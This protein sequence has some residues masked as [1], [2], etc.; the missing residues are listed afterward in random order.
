MNGIQVA[1]LFAHATVKPRFRSKLGRSHV[2][3]ASGSASLIWSQ[4]TL[5]N[6]RLRGVKALVCCMDIGLVSML[7]T[8]TVPSVTRCST[9][10]TT[11]RAIVVIRKEN[12]VSSIMIKGNQV[13]SRI[14]KLG[15]RGRSEE[16]VLPN[17]GVHFEVPFNLLPN[18]R[19]EQ[20]LTVGFGTIGARKISQSR[21]RHGIQKISKG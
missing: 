9:A 18:Y 5:V 14:P 12:V 20:Q 13:L 4:R 11:G 16:R 15:S 1:W 3:V 7:V 19:N 21:R 10:A 6:K 2:H 8:S 17:H